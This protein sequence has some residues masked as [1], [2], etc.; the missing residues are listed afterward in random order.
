MKL[1]RMAQI[2]KETKKQLLAE[3]P[4]VGS[5]VFCPRCKSEL[6]KPEGLAVLQCCNEQCSHRWF[7]LHTSTVQQQDKKK[8]IIVQTRGN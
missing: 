6:K 2:R 5:V 7:I 4:R 1:T 8:P 3:L